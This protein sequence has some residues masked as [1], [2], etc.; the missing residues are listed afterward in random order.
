MD[1]STKFGVYTEGGISKTFKT[2]RV[3]A[4]PLFF[5]TR[6]FDFNDNTQIRY[7]TLG[8]PLSLADQTN[9]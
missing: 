4:T 6:N 5:A 3:Y 1:A 7:I 8:G 2:I 9:F